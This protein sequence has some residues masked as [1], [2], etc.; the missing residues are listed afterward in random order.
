LQ[1][2]GIEP[3]LSSN[4]S[5]VHYQ[6]AMETGFTIGVLTLVLAS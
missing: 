3:T 2:V 1:R 5:K 4:P 6:S